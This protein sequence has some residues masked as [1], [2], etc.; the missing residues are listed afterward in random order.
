LCA[1]RRYGGLAPD[2]QALCAGR[3]AK[4]SEG[5]RRLL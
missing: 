2:R 5:H 4:R 3:P 1:W